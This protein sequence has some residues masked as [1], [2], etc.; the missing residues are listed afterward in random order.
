MVTR[1]P[2]WTLSSSEAEVE[3]VMKPVWRTVFVVHQSSSRRCRESSPKRTCMR[4]KCILQGNVNWRR[5]CQRPRVSDTM[6]ARSRGFRLRA[7]GDP[8][9]RTGSWPVQPPGESGA[10]IHCCENNLAGAKRLHSC[11]AQHVVQHK[12]RAR[13]GRRWGRGG[14]EEKRWTLCDGWWHTAH[15]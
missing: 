7:A 1:C 13:T 4:S 8:G 10:G 5:A 2:T 9:A 12:G 14:Y 11:T 3:Q 15:S 6:M